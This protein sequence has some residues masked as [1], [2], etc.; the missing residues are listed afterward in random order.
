MFQRN[1]GHRQK[2]M[3]GHTSQLPKKQLARLKESWAGTF[4]QE[5]FL[6]IPE[7][8]F[9]VLY[10]HKPSRPNIPVNILVGLEILKY[11]F[12][13]TDE[14]M[15]DAFCYNVQVRYAL[16]CQE[17]GEDHFE[18]RTVY[19]FRRRVVKHEQKTGENLFEQ[20]FKHI[21][22]EQLEA[23]PIETGKLRMD[24]T[25]IM[26]NIRERTRIQL[27]VE[28]LQRVHRMLDE[29]DQESYQ[30]AFE[31]YLQGSAEQYIY[32]LE[33][34]EYE[35]QL[36]AIGQ[37]MHQLVVELEAEYAE[38]PTYKMLERVFD[39]HFKGTED[40]DDADP[41]SGDE[42]SADSLQSPDDLEATYRQKRGEDYQGYVA[43]ITETC[44]P[45]NDLQ[46]IINVQL[47]PNT[48][49]D[50]EM[51]AESL[52]E[53][54]ERT[55]V[56]EAYTDGSYSS[57]EVDDAAEKY[58]V[59][60]IQSAIRGRKPSSEKFHLDDFE[61]EDTEE[62]Q[63]SNVTCPEE[64]AVEVNVGRK[65][66]RFLAYFDQTICQDCEAAQKGQCPTAKLKRT[67]RRV[68]RFSLQQF[69]VA[70]RRQRIAEAQES[71]QNLRAAV[72]ASIWSIKH[73]FPNG[74]V[75]VRGKTRVGMAIIS[76]TMM[77]NVK[78]IHRY[79]QEKKQQ[80]QKYRSRNKKKSILSNFVL[81]LTQGFLSL[82]SWL[83][84]RNGFNFNSMSF[85]G[86]RF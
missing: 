41:K 12:G 21:V 24:S 38:E 68:L 30:K 66:D 9:A 70:Q 76:P 72:E 69:R 65:E 56:E 35:S 45:E 4:Y 32:H 3:F 37:L 11:A 42:L 55:D 74:R 33:D 18:L 13:W 40:D 53:L 63:P 27:L 52:P 25:Q 60:Q 49:D 31:P 78:R 86:V 77:A 47:E 75:P 83:K 7:K 54:K 57:P 15:Y 82:L 14:Q 16:G 85:Y 2:S 50:A 22:D 20:V 64:Q 8:T 51:L 10:S 84:R 81:D 19:N 1:E 79:L 71:G 39:E 48:T 17:I 80:E 46:L 44:D 67:L 62:G 73:P 28:V 61:W 29:Q 59:R 43:N 26:S 5:V 58:Q 36:K 6:R 23:F 34:G